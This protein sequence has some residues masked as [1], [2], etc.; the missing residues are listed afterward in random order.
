[1]KVR[2]DVVDLLRAGI[3]QVEIARRLHISATTVYRIRQAIG[4]PSPGRG[5]RCMPSLDEAFHARS[6][7]VENG[8]RKW[9]GRHS[10]GMPTFIHDGRD[11]SAYRVAFRLRW[12]REPV[13]KALPSCEFKGCVALDHVEDRPMRDKNRATYAAIFGGLP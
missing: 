4:L 12:Q 13:G 9:I 6:V 5:H 11:L 1:M 10:R 3:P 8:H 7:P 2:H